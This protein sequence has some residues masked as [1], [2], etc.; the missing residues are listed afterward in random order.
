MCLTL[1]PPALSLLRDLRREP[2]GHRCPMPHVPCLFGYV[3][4]L[5]TN[6]RRWSWLNVIYI[7]MGLLIVIAQAH[8]WEGI[9]SAI[10][11]DISLPYVSVSVSLNVLLT[12]MIVT[13]LILHGRNVRAATGSPTGIGGLYKAV[14][15]MLIESSALYSMNSLLLIGLWATE[16]EAAGAFLPIIA[17]VQVREFPR[18]RSANTLSNMTMDLTGDRSAAHHQT[19]REPERVDERHYRHRTH[20]FFVPR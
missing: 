18:P 1:A 16:S 6:R 19:S 3:S 14:A 17:E 2:L 4:E 8:G 11:R 5:S 7:A 10:L 13:R 9:W 15:T 20:W 12:L